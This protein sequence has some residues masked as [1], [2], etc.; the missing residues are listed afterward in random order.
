MSYLM[1]PQSEWDWRD[2]RS[3]VLD[4]ME[5][6]SIPRADLSSAAES[7][8]FKSFIKRWGIERA[9]EIASAGFALGKGFWG[10]RP[11]NQ[12]SFAAKVDPFFAVPVNEMIK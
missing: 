6:N 1:R 3:F 12:Y 7:S 2:F 11:I 8:I 4:L 5:E 9:A 10:G